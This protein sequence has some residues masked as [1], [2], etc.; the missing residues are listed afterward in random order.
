MYVPKHFVEDDPARVSQLIR[1]H[2]FGTLVSSDGER[3]LATHLPML[4]RDLPGRPW[5]LVGHIARAN[6]QWKTFDP[7]R[8]VLAIFQ[9]AHTYVSARWYSAPNA[10]TWNY[11]SV[12]VYGIPSIVS[13]GEELYELLR[14]LVD[15]QEKGAAEAERFRL[16]SIPAGKVESMMAAIVGFR[17]TVTR[18]EAAAKLSQNQD[19]GDHARVIQK[20]KD[21]GDADSLTVAREM[22]ERGPGR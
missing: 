17:I 4:L 2:P 21:R 8:E 14:D 9:G 20:L 1:H 22:E 11:S 12:H 18:V 16:E 3:P 19:A 7:A 13:D 5:E 6:P 15:S 10:P